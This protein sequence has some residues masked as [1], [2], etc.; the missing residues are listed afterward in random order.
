MANPA[1]ADRE[2]SHWVYLSPHLDDAVLSCGGMIWE[3]MQSGTRVEIWTICTAD[4]L[5]GSL[6]PFARSMH[7]RWGTKDDAMST[8]RSEDALAAIRLGAG[9]NYLGLA[10]CIY[11]R[12]P[13]SGDPVINCEEDLWQALN[14][15]ELPLVHNLTTYLNDHLPDSA[16]L[17]SP[18]G[19]GGHLDHR[20]TRAAAEALS[21]QCHYYADYPYA[22][23]IDIRQWVDPKWD[24]LPVNVSPIA[25]NAWQEA[26]AAYASQISSFWVHLGQMRLALKEYW[27]NGGGCILYRG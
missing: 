1:P 4:P 20:L 19:I 23:G 13:N 22:A 16:S 17:V 21:R 12:L 27:Q 10:D 24:Q 9:I 3:Q 7:A 25:L 6:T 15:Q 2:T 18:I 14:Q 8:R 11:R 26:V 5:P